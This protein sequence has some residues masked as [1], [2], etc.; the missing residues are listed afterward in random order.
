MTERNDYSLTSPEN[1][2]MFKHT[3]EYIYSYLS[4]MY[5]LP[6]AHADEVKL[7]LLQYL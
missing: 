5:H 2:E 6:S 4:T 1:R 3:V 7:L